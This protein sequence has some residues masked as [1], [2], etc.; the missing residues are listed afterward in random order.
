MDVWVYTDGASHGNPGEAG[1]GVVIRQYKGRFSLRE[2]SEY[3]GWATAAEAEYKAIIRGLQEAAVLGASR[4]TI[5]CDSTI[6][7]NH[8][9]GRMQAHTP[10]ERLLLSEVLDLMAGF[11]SVRVMWMDRTKNSEAD[12]LATAAIKQHHDDRYNSS[13]YA[14]LYLGSLVRGLPEGSN[15]E[16][17]DGWVVRMPHN[18]K[19][20][21]GT[22]STPE[23]AIKDAQLQIARLMDENQRKRVQNSFGRQK[24][25]SQTLPD[26]EAINGTCR[27]LTRTGI[28]A[29]GLD[30]TAE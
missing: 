29:L 18:A 16:R 8:I 21:I 10:T 26:Q 13:H 3:I 19:T 22:G 9:N 24:R 11:Q 6:I 17:W 25:A 7:V 4:V 30:S 20:V 2:I 27:R 28:R 5:C 1:I 14:N 12:A 15:I 23:A